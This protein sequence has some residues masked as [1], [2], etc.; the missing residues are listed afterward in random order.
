[1]SIIRETLKGLDYVLYIVPTL[2]LVSQVTKDL[3]NLKREYNLHDIEVF[4]SYQEKRTKNV[5]Y[6]LTQERAISAFN[7]ENP[8]TGLDILVVDEIQNIERV[9]DESEQ[10][11]KI[12]YD[13]LKEIK[14]L[15]KPSKIILS[16]ARLKNM[17]LLRFSCS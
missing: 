2:S 3:T 10:R 5:I 1:M 9:A 13:V 17:A 12:L 16:G 6:V 8:F 11:S 4:N 14:H 15:V 7:H